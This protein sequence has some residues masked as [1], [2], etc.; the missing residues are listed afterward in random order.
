MD[1]CWARFWP[2]SLRTSTP[3][4]SLSPPRVV[5][6]RFC[7]LPCEHFLREPSSCVLCRLRLPIRCSEHRP[8]HHRTRHWRRG[9]RSSQVRLPSSF[10]TIPILLLTTLVK[11]ALPAL[12]GRDQPSGSPGL[13][14]GPGAIRHRPWRGPWILDWV[15]HP[16][17][18]VCSTLFVY[19]LTTD[20]MRR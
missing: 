12:H 9:C 2:V 13:P 3:G 10:E 7:T 6:Y 11:H 4:G 20:P 8:S 17:L 14:H 19:T 15:L 18:Y 5:S 1:L 16:R